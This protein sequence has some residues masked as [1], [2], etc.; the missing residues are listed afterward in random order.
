MQLNGA[1]GKGSKND[2]SL[3]NSKCSNII[4]RYISLPSVPVM[5]I[6]QGLSAVPNALIAVAEAPLGIIT[7]ER[8]K[9]GY[10]LP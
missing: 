4:T 2:E 5:S 3:V 9:V 8:C 1:G 10:K 7:G 6:A